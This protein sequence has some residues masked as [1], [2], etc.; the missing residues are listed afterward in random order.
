MS[1]FCKYR[2]E[3]EDFSQRIQEAIA[4]GIDERL[5]VIQEAAK[6]DWRAA[7]W[8]C[9]RVHAEHFAR[10]RVELTG[11]NGAPLSLSAGVQ[12]YLPQKESPVEIAAPLPTLTL[13]ERNGSDGH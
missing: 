9:E 13:S 6:T 8:Y 5:R 1:S 3:N 2:A 11:A 7:A 4:T 12:I 10:N